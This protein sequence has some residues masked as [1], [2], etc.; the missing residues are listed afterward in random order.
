MTSRMA[1]V[2]L[3]AGIVAAGWSRPATAQ[4]PGLPVYGGGFSTG[5]TFTGTAGFPGS[6]TPTGDGTAYGLSATLG[7]SRI[8]FTGTV[9]R[10]DPDGPA[11]AKTIGGGNVT[12]KFFGGPLVP[13]AAYLQA[14]YSRWDRGPRT[15]H[16]VPVALGISLVLPSTLVA[17]KPW[18]APRIDILHKDQETCPLVNPSCDDT[19]TRFGLSGGVDLTTLSGFGL[20]AALDRVGNDDPVFSLGLSFG[21]RIPG[22]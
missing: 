14:G 6:D 9:S 20:H 15:D 4:N 19:D 12:Y 1:R 2:L 17:V 7:L 21:L 16:H 3:A 11:D 13:L 10:F 5:L 22:L 8:A 18:I